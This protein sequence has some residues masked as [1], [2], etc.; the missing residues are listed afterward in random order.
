ML[1]AMLDGDTTLEAR[2]LRVVR[3]ARAVVDGVDFTARAGRVLAILGPNGAGKSSLVKAV[4]GILPSEGDIAI[5]GASVRAMDRTERARR[6]A[7][8]PQQSELRAALTVRDVVAQGRY[9]HRL[10]GLRT[11]RADDDATERALAR[12]DAGALAERPFTA[13]SHGERQRVL[14][15][16]AIATGARVLLLDEPTASLDVGH[17][18]R[19][20]GLLRDLAGAGACVVTV[21]HPLERAIEW[22]DDALLLHE[23]RVVAFGPSRD[24]I[25]ARET[26]RVYGVDLVPNGALGFRLGAA[27]ARGSAS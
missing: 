1:D 14:V 18:L 13:I 20:Y 19:L 3:G 10:G 2:R 4:V 22:T 15:A 12:V 8:V 23:G 24:V 9:P 7:Y 26:E 21:L 17:A 6:M 27:G 16:R 11:T 25:G 5:G